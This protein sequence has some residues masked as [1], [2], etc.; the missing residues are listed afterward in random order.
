MNL[1]LPVGWLPLGVMSA[2]EGQI[3]LSI[4]G[5]LGMTLIGTVSLWR[6]YRTTIRL[7]QGQ[8]TN[9]KGR[10]ARAVARPASGRKPGDLLV[11]ARI[12]GLSEP[13]SA[14]ALGELPL[15][16]TRAR[17]EDD[18]VDAPDHVR[19]LR[20][21]ALD[22]EDR[23]S[24]VDPAVVRH[25]SDGLCASRP[26]ADHGQSIRFR[27]RRLSCFRALRGARRDILLGK[28]LAFSPLALGMATVLLAV[29][30]ILCPLRLDHF[31]AMFPQY[32]SMFLLFCI[33]AN[34]L[35]IYTPLHVAAG[36]L[37]PSNPKLSTILLQL[38]MV[39]ILLPL[40]QG[41][42]LLP[43]GIEALSHFLGWTTAAPICLVL[44]LAECAL[45]VV[46]YRFALD[47]QGGLLQAREQRILETVTS[48]AP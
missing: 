17:G 38:A 28:N 22:L 8:P 24:S 43:L 40:T 13:V 11:E 10:P 44:T 14:I 39:F 1:V 35:S 46:L 2:A 16:P 30:Q 19:R 23:H 42:T 45:V 33:S 31:L 9:R 47:W 20:L 29:V 34:L 41:P 15:A 48:R 36:V 4:P 26:P 27:P 7:Y 25:R 6:A 37:K 21:H 18:V 3:L 5:L 12:P 32:V